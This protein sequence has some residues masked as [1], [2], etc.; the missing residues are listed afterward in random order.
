MRI[1]ILGS[2]RSEDA[3]AWSQRD[4]PG[5]QAAVERMARALVELGHSLVVGSDA[6]HTADAI[7]ARAVAASSGG[8]HRERIH[9]LAPEADAVRFP[10][11]RGEHPR[12]F[13]E[14]A[15]P[16]DRQATAKV[17]QVR[18][19]DA[20]L[21]VGGARMT[22]QAGLTAA[23]SGKRLVCVGSFGGAAS[24]L[25]KLFMSSRGNWGNNVGGVKDLALLQGPWSDVLVEDVVLG[26]RANRKPRILVIHGRA[27][28]RDRLK[29]H[30]EGLGLPKPIVLVDEIVP[31]RHIGTKFEELASV[32]DAAIAVCT[33]DD[34][35]ALADGPGGAVTSRAR[36][37]VWLETGWFWGR[38]GLDRVLMLTR[39]EIELPSDLLGL[40]MYGYRDEPRERAAEIDA[41][42]ARV[43]EGRP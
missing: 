36:Q 11:L 32:V 43:G 23:V 29:A 1:A 5:F 31:S 13:L 41:F 42:L 30:L 33:P 3:S 40:E 27:P 19:A 9:V 35:A 18:Y 37:N 15:I 28:D 21:L 12:L 10:D 14:I 17:F 25:N 38:L 34:L 26:L 39:G 16:A 24:T 8:E 22:Q 2:W 20:I 4:E 6:P 7:A